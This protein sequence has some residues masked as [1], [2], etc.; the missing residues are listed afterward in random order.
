VNV[1]IIIVF[2]SGKES[3]EI[4]FGCKPRSGFGTASFLS[5]EEKRK[6]K[7]LDKFPPA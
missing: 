1:A 4:L 7:K 2:D 6:E 5:K 3:D